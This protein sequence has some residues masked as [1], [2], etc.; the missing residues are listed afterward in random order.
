[1]KLSNLDQLYISLMPLIQHSAKENLKKVKQ[2]KTYLLY[3]N[4]LSRQLSLFLKG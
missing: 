1:M 4:Y 3:T 2:I